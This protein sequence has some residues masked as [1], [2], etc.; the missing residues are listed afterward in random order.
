MSS[1]AENSVVV[2]GTTKIMRGVGA[3]KRSLVEG[4]GG[5]GAGFPHH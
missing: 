4:L 5:G 2:K 3:K 1:Q